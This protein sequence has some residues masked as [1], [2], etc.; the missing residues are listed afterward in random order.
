MQLYRSV[1]REKMKSDVVAAA[2]E[3]TRVKASVR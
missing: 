3:R 1:R 2:K